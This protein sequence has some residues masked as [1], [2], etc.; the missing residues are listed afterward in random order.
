MIQAEFFT[1]LI[2]NVCNLLKSSHHI[3]RLL[4]SSNLGINSCCDYDTINLPKIFMIALI[5]DNK[6]LSFY[7]FWKKEMSLILLVCFLA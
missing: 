4:C 5:S 1:I 2:T 3:R 6:E 7:F